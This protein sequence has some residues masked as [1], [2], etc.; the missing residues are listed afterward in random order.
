MVFFCP[1]TEIEKI[2]NKSTI[3][4]IPILYIVI[5]EMISILIEKEEKRREKTN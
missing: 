1:N 4:V 5:S 3:V 2:E